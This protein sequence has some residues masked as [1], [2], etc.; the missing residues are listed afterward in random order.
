MR[1][2]SI[3]ALLCAAA[4]LAVPFEALGSN[5]GLLSVND[6][7]FKGAFRIPAANDSVSSMEWSEG[8]MGYNPDRHSVYLVGHAW[9]QAI[10]EFSVPEL[11]NSP[12]ISELNQAVKLQDFSRVL[13]RPPNIQPLAVNRVGGISYVR[14]SNGPVL[15]VTAYVYYTGDYAG[16]PQNVMVIRDPSRLSTSQIDGYFSIQGRYAYSGRIAPIPEEWQASLGGTHTAGQSG[17]IAVGGSLEPGLASLDLSKITDQPPSSVPNPVPVNSLMLLQGDGFMTYQERRTANDMWTME[18]IGSVEFIV[19][20]TRTYVIIGRH[21]GRQSGI[22]YKCTNNFGHAYGGY[23]APDGDDYEYYYWFFDVN[24]LVAVRQG[25][26]RPVDV[27]PYAKGPLPNPIAENMR[28]MTRIGGGTYDAA[29]GLLY[30]TLQRHGNPPVVAVYEVGA[31]AGGAVAIPNPP[32]GVR[33]G[34]D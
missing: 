6:L 3:C 24:D 12:N 8:P 16:T 7:S 23:G 15:V 26:M 20:G 28:W 17:G 22:C 27:R 25:K 5:S 30:V 19:P 29:S 9:H 34:P 14:T 31:P 18:S 2:F 4:A 10:A 1:F 21:G 11:V 32:T 33:V 13:G